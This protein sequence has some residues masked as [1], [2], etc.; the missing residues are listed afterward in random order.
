MPSFCCTTV[1]RASPAAFQASG[2]VTS[3][4]Q[5]QAAA[6]FLLDL[7]TAKAEP[8]AM[9]KAP[10]ARLTKF[11]SPSVTDSPQASTKIAM[12]T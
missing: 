4:A 5:A 11:I 3:R 12:V 7:G 1:A 2:E 10:C 6:G 9:P 8:P